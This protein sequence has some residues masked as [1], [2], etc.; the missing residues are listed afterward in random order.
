MKRIMMLVLLSA[1]FI[2][3]KEM[4]KT[5][6]TQEKGIEIET[7]S[8]NT[9]LLKNGCTVVQLDNVIKNVSDREI[10]SVTY[11]I[12]LLD[13]N[14]EL[15]KSYRH[16]Y[17]GENRTL[18]HG[19]SIN[20]HFGTQDRLEKQ[21]SSYKI[22]ITDVKDTTELPLVHLPLPGEYLYEAI[23]L[24]RLETEFPVKIYVRIDHG[25]AEQIAEITDEETIRQMVTL[26]KQIKIGKESDVFVTDNYNLV[27][28][29][30]SDETQKGISLNLCNLE[31]HNQGREHIYEL[32][33]F[34]PFWSACNALAKAEY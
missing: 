23:D 31:I 15:I 27:I 24:Y 8:F 1:L 16:S 10:S 28:F 3:Y 13:E 21:P 9:K 5:V 32:D 25:G 17:F 29:Y 18:S 6:K 33:D 11:E 7:I 14:G 22:V 34:G 30:F 19:Q 4:E 12:H 26:F 2:G 20:D